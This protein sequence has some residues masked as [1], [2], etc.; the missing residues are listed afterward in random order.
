MSL[1]SSDEPLGL[2]LWGPKCA[3][4]FPLGLVAIPT[5]DPSKYNTYKPHS[6]RISLSPPPGRHPHPGGEDHGSASVHDQVDPHPD[7]VSRT[8]HQ[9]WI[10]QAAF[11]PAAQGA[12]GSEVCHER[13]SKGAKLGV[14]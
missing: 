5:G 6:L 8:Q 2:G 13:T 4:P 10:Q 12:T 14:A 7:P 11:R 9:P 1:G 3:G